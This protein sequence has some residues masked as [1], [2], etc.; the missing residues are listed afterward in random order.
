MILTSEDDV[1]RFNRWAATYDQSLM[2][3]WYF[4]LIHS[5]MLDL[6][7]QDKLTKPPRCILDVGCGT[8]RLLRAASVRW[9]EAQ[10]FGVDPAELMITEAKRNNPNAMFKVGSAEE[11]PFADQSVDLI[12]SS[13]SFHHW[14]NQSKGLQEI[15][16]VLCLGGRFCLANHTLMLARIFKEKVKSRNQ[17]RALISGTG[18]NI[19]LHRRM[20]IRFVVIILARK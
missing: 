9:P 3:R 2:Q 17:I 5:K 11:L 19:V 14:A 7:E 1:N 18:L 12:L 4:A 8:G 20:W 13:L 15:A 6:L 10:L 16:R